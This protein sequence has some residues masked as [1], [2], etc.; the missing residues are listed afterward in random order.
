MLSEGILKSSSAQTKSTF[1]CLPQVLRFRRISWDAICRAI[2]RKS[3]R[4]WNVYL[5]CP[6][7]SSFHFSFFFAYSKIRRENPAIKVFLLFLFSFCIFNIKE[8]GRSMSDF[9][10]I[11][12][13]GGVVGLAIARRLSEKH[14]NLLLLEKHERCGMET[15]SRNS[16]VIHAGIY[17]RPGSLKARLCV[18]GREALYA[19][20]R[21]ENIPH[22]NIT[23]IISSAA[24]EELPRLELIQKNAAQNGVHLDFLDK[25]ATLRLEPNIRTFGS[26]YSSVTGVVSV[27]DLMNYYQRTAVANGAT[28]QMR[29]QVAGIERRQSGYEVTIDEGGTR[30]AVTG[31]I[32]INAA[33]LES[34]TIAALAGIDINQAGYRLNYVK[35][36]YFMITPSKSKLLSRLVYPVPGNEGLGVHALLDWSGRLKFGPDVEYLENRVQDYTVAE[37]KRRTFAE[38]IRRIL[39]MI[40][41]DDI[42]PDMS[43]IRPKLQKKGEP[44][45]DFVIVNEKEKGLPGFIDLIG[46][47]SPGLTSSLAIARYVE[48]LL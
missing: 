27:H 14:P 33:G 19:L 34:D 8:K 31:E 39:P 7:C 47:D 45:K 35:G 26:L 23:K 5:L 3:F 6:L 20:C 38:A 17:Y 37:T 24:E 9:E 10:I 40:T 30:S 12:I 29:C 46:I 48:G 32:V 13:G 1:I 25:A 44:E 28:V 18:E 4:V 16:E 42:T 22:R 43:G 15:S 41:D 21:R 36:S 11:I 2:S